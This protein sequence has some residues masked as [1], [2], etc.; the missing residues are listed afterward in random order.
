MTKLSGIAERQH[1]RRKL[2][3][4]PESEDEEAQEIRRRTNLKTK[5]SAKKVDSGPSD[6][7]DEVGSA[8]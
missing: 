1:T 3:G 5:P 4:T 7:E 8:A 6:D 2:L